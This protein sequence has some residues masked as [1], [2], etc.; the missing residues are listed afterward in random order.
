[1]TNLE[2]PVCKIRHA[3]TADVEQMVELIE[4][5]RARLQA[6]EPVFWNRAED[7]AEK[8]RPWFE[9]L[10][11]DAAVL[12]LAAESESLIEGFLIAT[13]TPAPPVYDPGGA[14]WMIDDFAVAEASLWQTVG[15]DLIKAAKAQI[16]ERGGK[17]IVVVAPV[18]EDDQIELLK[19]EG[20]S[21][22][23]IWLTQ[24]L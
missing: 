8:T 1:M 3:V 18:K 16:L 7:A 2:S 10:V 14:T 9:A 19:A 22:A 6:Y 21:A 17:Q 12:S 5:R 24:T 11:Q 4:V 23:S 13:E 20:L 15:Q